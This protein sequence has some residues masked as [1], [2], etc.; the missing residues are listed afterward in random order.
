MIS[1][2]ASGAGSTT[3][4]ASVTALHGQVDGAL[5]NATPFPARAL[6]SVLPVIVIG[7]A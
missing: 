4:I 6:T 2:M 5:T 3:N 1:V 7:A